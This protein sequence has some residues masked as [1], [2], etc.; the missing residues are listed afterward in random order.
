MKVTDPA[1]IQVPLCLGRW[2]NV[3][4][5]VSKK[6]DRETM[7]VPSPRARLTGRLQS[8]I[9]VQILF[10][11]F[12]SKTLAETRSEVRAPFENDECVHCTPPTYQLGDETALCAD[13]LQVH[14]GPGGISNT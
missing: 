5:E 7:L 4:G 12:P 11:K 9:R 3:F 13:L 6:S 1:R 10:R 14:H 2:A 8:V